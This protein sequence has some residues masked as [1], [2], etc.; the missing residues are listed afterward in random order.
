MPITYKE[1]FSSR[2]ERNEQYSLYSHT[3]HI[4]VGYHNKQTKKNI[5]VRLSDG[6]KCYAEKSG[7]HKEAGRAGVAD[8]GR[9][10][11]VGSVDQTDSGSHSE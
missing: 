1:L 4:L 6:E 5:F 3:A 2:G 9:E 8:P 10:E 7:R 11:D